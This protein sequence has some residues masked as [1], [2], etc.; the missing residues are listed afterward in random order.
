MIGSE[1]VY[2][3]LNIFETILIPSL[4]F[5]NLIYSSSSPNLKKIN[6]FFLQLLKISYISKLFIIMTKLMIN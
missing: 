3:F 4:I 5:Y 6:I 1:I 2:I